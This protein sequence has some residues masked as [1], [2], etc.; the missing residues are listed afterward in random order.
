MAARIVSENRK[1]RF[2]IA[3]EQTFEAG[4]S[5]TGDEIKA[6]RA[7]RA[8]LTG[9]YVKPWNGSMVLHGLHLSTA[10]QPDRTRSLL[11]SK[12]EIAEIDM[13]LRRKGVAAVA[14]DIHFRGS[15]AKVSIGV[16]PGRKA[17]DKRALIKERD[18]EREAR[19]G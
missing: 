4:L 14:L 6:I 12:K 3:I 5:L 13:L 19:R 2:D 9:A 17:Q 1:A 10:K 8:Q 18:L 15:W 7:G 16:G 11:L